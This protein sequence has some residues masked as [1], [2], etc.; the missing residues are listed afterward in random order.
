M[1]KILMSDQTMGMNI[2]ELAGQMKTPT[3]NQSS[4][5]VKRLVFGQEVEIQHEKLIQILQEIELL[6]RSAQAELSK[7]DSR[8]KQHQLLMENFTTTF[9]KLDEASKF[10]DQHSETKGISEALQK[11]WSKIGTYFKV[12]KSN[13]LLERN[14]ILLH[15]LLEKFHDQKG[16]ES[17]FLT[18][19]DFKNT[20][21]QDI[22]K[23]CDLSIQVL[24]SLR[25]MATD[26]RANSDREDLIDRFYSYL[27]GVF[28]ACYHV[29]QSNHLFA[30]SLFSQLKKRCDG[31]HKALEKENKDPLFVR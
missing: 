26:L 20:K 10:C 4:E 27:R 13:K 30:L 22:I 18:K 23:L 2:E 9:N 29:S 3:A 1:Q 8:E 5:S 31:L 19:V 6:E 25:D 7:S 15:Q 14:W 11:L 28:V 12:T 16:F 17:L 21:P 24:Q